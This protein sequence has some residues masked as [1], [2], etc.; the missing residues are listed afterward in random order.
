MTIRNRAAAAAVVLL[1][2]GFA[3]AQRSSGPGTGAARVSGRIVDPSGT[4][5][6]NAQVSLRFAPPGQTNAVARTGEDG[7][8]T[9]RG[10][11]LKCEVT[12]ESPGFKTAVKTVGAGTGGEI[13]FGDIVLQIGVGRGVAVE[14]V[15]PPMLTVVGIGGT[16]AWLS[17][18]HLAILPQRTVKTADDGTPV[19]FQGALLTDVL[20]EVDRPTGEK[21]HSTS[22]S[23]CVVV[24]GKDGYR[25]TFAWAELD[26]TFMDKPVYLVTQR[27]GKPLPET[28]GPFQLVVPGE[29]RA[30][31]W[32]RQVTVLRIQRAS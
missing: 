32:V 18:A 24:E 2:S 23:Y 17:A 13:D 28:D 3:N 25:A 4:P 12:V 9:F 27:G 16:I 10:E 22:A 31:R 8:F 21:F 30:A 7:T 19:E 1:L 26:S 5:V 29:K 14:V 20:A 15:A 6:P 11:P